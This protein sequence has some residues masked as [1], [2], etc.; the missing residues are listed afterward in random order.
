M[1]VDD[2]T[3]EP[4]RRAWND[5]IRNGIVRETSVVTSRQCDTYIEQDYELAGTVFTA[6]VPEA[7]RID[8]RRKEQVAEMMVG[9]YVL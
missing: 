2:G 7:W 1:V 5:T 8:L 4:V 6:H 3:A 9:E